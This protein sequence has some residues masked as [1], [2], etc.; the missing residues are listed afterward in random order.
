MGAAE[1]ENDSVSALMQKVA[2]AEARVQ[3]EILA[4]KQAKKAL[5]DRV[6]VSIDE[7]V[8]GKFIPAATFAGVKPGFAFRTGEEGPGYYR[9][10]TEEQA[11][12]EQLRKAVEGN[13]QEWGWTRDVTYIVRVD[14]PIGVPVYNKK[15]E[16]TFYNTKTNSKKNG[17]KPAADAAEDAVEAPESNTP[18][19]HLAPVPGTRIILLIILFALSCC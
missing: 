19:T 11:L 5:A 16:V 17:K 3:T 10:T 18:L 1:G 4:A 7:S 6:A 8:G 2:D 15:P 12:N 9:D 13:K 14:D